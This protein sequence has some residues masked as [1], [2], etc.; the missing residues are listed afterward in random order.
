M[1]SL[2]LLATFGTLLFAAVPG[3][4]A[5][6]GATT[7]FTLTGSNV[8][9]TPGA[10]TVTLGSVS[11]TNH[12]LVGVGRIDAAA[13]DAFGETLGSVSG[14]QVSNWT[15]L[16]GGSYGGTFNFT[17]DRGYNAG[18]LFSNYA[19]RIQTVDFTFTPYTGTATSG[20]AQ[21]QF[22]LTY[23]GATSTKLS[24]DSGGGNF[25]HTTGLVPDSSTTLAGKTVPYVTVS[26][27]GATNT[28]TGTTSVINRLSLDTE[29]LVLRGDGSG[30]V[31]DEY[32]ANIYHFNAAKQIDAVITPP[33]AVLPSS[34]TTSLNLTFSSEVSNVSGRR[35][36][37]GMEGVAVSPDG[38]KLFGL[39]QSATIQ[40]SGSGNQGRLNTR[41]FVY[42]V[43]A[44]GTST[45]L[46]AEYVLKLPVLNDTGTGAPNKTA[47]QSEIIA[48][49]ST[50]LLV[51]SREGNGK[52]VTTTV[53]A[54]FKTVIL[55][56]LATGTNILGSFDNLSG[57]GGDI[58]P[59]GTTLAP[60]IT[61]MTYA[62]AVN[63]LNT[64][65]LGIFDL[66]VNSGATANLNTLSEKWE[67]LSLVPTE[68]PNEYF[69]F[70]ANDNDFIS[71][72]TVMRGLDGN[73]AAGV[74]AITAA[75]IPVQN[76]TMFL[77]YRVSLGGINQIQAV[78]AIPE[79]STYAALLSVAVLGL[80]FW[81]RRRAAS[82][83]TA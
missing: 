18:G 53:G 70:V 58:T 57:L 16:G 69:L 39:M 83:K 75:G 76:D 21:N 17:P 15:V 14:L 3:L 80:A 6:F 63:L 73:L 22:S 34:S 61:P 31:S 32:G 66:N 9:A 49:D 72:S 26:N 59:S 27:G 35:G 67:G 51:L 41:L 71:G 42:D 45:T 46:S 25:V 38:T 37:Q 10:T 64:A 43:N 44:T 2:R 54:V 7:A 29:G 78:S 56:D 24:Y 79:P 30:F 55:V 5:Q 50:H 8:S 62:E 13:V 74:N 28:T 36:N 52:G 40:D 68:N 23:N 65:Q 1:K 12:G 77:A 20:V 81:Q 19:A 82:G 11:F 47:A 4:C 60:G 33:A 48:L